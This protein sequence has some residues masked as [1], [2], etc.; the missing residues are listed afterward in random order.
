MTLN[1]IRLLAIVSLSLTSAHAQ[2]ASVASA[3]G[4]LPLLGVIGAG[5]LAGGVLSLMRTRHQ[6]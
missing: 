3:N 2:A 1:A 5:V 4:E 6:K